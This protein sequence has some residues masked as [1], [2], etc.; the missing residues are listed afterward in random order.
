[1]FNRSALKSA[2]PDCSCNTLPA[3]LQSRLIFGLLVSQYLTILSIPALNA[4]IAISNAAFPVPFLTAD[5]EPLYPTCFAFLKLS[6]K[7]L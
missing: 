4:T 3:C 5:G 1:L 6:I 7:I 2:D